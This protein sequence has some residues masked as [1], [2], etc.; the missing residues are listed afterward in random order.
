LP[1][2]VDPCSKSGAHADIEVSKNIYSPTPGLVEL[3]DRNV[4]MPVGLVGNFD[5]DTQMLGHT[6]RKIPGFWD[7]SNMD[8]VQRSVIFYCRLKGYGCKKSTGS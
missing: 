3:P 7:V 6:R 2:A 1:S 4:M 8:V 5:A